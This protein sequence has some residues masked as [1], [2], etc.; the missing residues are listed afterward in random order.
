MSQFEQYITPIL[1]LLQ[2]HFELCYF[3]IKEKLK[4]MYII[5]I[6]T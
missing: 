5:L 6:F 3:R 1:I 2:L 4:T